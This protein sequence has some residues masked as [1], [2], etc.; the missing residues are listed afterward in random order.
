MEA[1]HRYRLLLYFVALVLCLSA[2]FAYAEG[3]AASEANKPARLLFQT[4]GPRSTFLPHLDQSL[5]TIAPA[6]EMGATVS[7]AKL[8]QVS[9]YFGKSHGIWH[10]ITGI[11]HKSKVIVTSPQWNMHASKTEPMTNAAGNLKGNG[12]SQQ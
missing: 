1:T 2:C 9:N 8:D 11:R 12:Q 6:T 7:A 10:N 5:M 3:P 4:S